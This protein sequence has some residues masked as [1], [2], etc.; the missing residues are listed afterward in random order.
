MMRDR[1]SPLPSARPEKRSLMRAKFEI[2]GKL[3]LIRIDLQ[4]S[5]VRATDSWIKHSDQLFQGVEVGYECDQE[6]HAVALVVIV[7]QV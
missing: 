1:R 7:G 4:A 6:R 5:L 3:P 2:A